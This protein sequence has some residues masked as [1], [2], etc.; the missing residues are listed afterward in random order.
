M[1]YPF[2][3]AYDG[4]EFARVNHDGKWSVDWAKTLNYRFE[5][6]T[7]RNAAVV[8]FA[9]ALMAAKDNFFLTTWQASDDTKDAWPH[10]SQVLDVE[11]NEPEVGSVRGNFALSSMGATAARVNYDGSWSVNWPT[12]VELSREPLTNYKTV[13]VIAFCQMMMAA[14]YRFQT[15]AWNVAVVDDD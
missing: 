4:D 3:I 6:L 9:N 10:K 1:G 12:V 7:P 13:A 8:A 15:S 2:I 11:S 14:Q 5:P